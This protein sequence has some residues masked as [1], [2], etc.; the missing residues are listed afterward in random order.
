[1][2]ELTRDQ[3]LK[4][5]I[6]YPS[7][8]IKLNTTNHFINRLEERGLGLDCIPTMVRVTKDNIHSGKTK[9]GKT[10]KSVVVRLVYSPTK[11]IFLCFNPYDGFLKTLWFKDRKYDSGRRREISSPKDSE[12]AVQDDKRGCEI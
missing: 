10:L 5:I 11:F 9:N 1:M 2:Q 12:Q 3:I 8:L 7:N 6:Q 4:G